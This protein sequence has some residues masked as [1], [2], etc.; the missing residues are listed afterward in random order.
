MVTTMVIDNEW[1]ESLKKLSMKVPDNWWPGYT[2]QILHDGKI[3]SFDSTTQKWNLLLDSNDDDDLYLMA[4]DAVCEYSNKQ[5]STFHKFQLPHQPVY[6]GDDEFETADGTRYTA[7][8][9]SEWNRCPI[10]PVTWTSGNEDFTV[11][12]TPKEVKTLMDAN[13]EI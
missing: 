1:A 5:S 7:T 6:E 10:D 11:N 13:K 9:T 3:D 4:Y 8:P 12:I 2:D